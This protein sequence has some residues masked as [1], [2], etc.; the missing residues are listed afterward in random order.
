MREQREGECKGGWEKVG[1]KR[2]SMLI[3]RATF[4]AEVNVTIVMD[5]RVTRVVYIVLHTDGHHV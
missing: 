4:E 1:R 2:V 5:E 3:S